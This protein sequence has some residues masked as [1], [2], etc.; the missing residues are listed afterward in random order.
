M[1]GASNRPIGM[2]LRLDPSRTAAWTAMLLLA[3]GL[4]A[5]SYA[6][7]AIVDWQR[8]ASGSPPAGLVRIQYDSVWAF[9]FADR[10]RCL[11]DHRLHSPR[12][13]ADSSHPSQSRAALRRGQLQR[14]GRADCAC[15]R[16]DGFRAWLIARGHARSMALR[17]DCYAGL[18]RAGAGPVVALRRVDRRH[19]G[20]GAAS[21]RRRPH[22]RP[23]ILGAW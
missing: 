3:A 21:Y 2:P 15:V 9:A 12:R 6:C 19:G 11:A 1:P 20:V 14:H 23:A 4:I 18:G 17:P 5:A 13:N 10:A 22:Q 7:W 16:G 8:A